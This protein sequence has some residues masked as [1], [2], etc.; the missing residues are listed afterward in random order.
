MTATATVPC[1]REATPATCPRWCNGEHTHGLTDN[2]TV[3]VS[4]P[5]VW[6]GDP[7]YGTPSYAVEFYRSDEWFDGELII[8]QADMTVTVS[9]GYESEINAAGW[10]VQYGNLQAND[11]RRLARWL[12]DQAR[13]I[14]PDRTNGEPPEDPK[15]VA[16][17]RAR[18]SAAHP[19]NTF[20]TGL[21]G[22][23][24]GLT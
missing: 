8:G 14:D 17:R 20:V 23:D 4:D 7:T 21:G 18:R 10:C 3:H 6:S 24:G 22:P 12:A 13:E 1:H 11:A 16:T 5:R 19:S 2:S 15:R 9:G